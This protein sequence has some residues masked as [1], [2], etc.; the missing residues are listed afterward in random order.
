M[1]NLDRKILALKAA[2]WEG[3]DTDKLLSKAVRTYKDVMNFPKADSHI[4]INGKEVLIKDVPQILNNQKMY[5]NIRLMAAI[6]DL[7]EEKYSN[8]KKIP[9]KIEFCSLLS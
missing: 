5:E 2:L 8:N 3:G 9:N 6:E 4:Y 7:V 1:N